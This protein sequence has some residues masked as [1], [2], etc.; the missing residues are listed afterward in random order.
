[1]PRLLSRANS[2]RH[3]TFLGAV[4]TALASLTVLHAAQN[5]GSE[6]SRMQAAAADAMQRKID[7]IKSNADAASV[8]QRPTVF[9]QS[10]INAYFA[11]HRVRTP[12]GVKAARFVLGRA[13]VTAYAR[14]DFDQI[15]EPARSRNPLLSIFSGT[16][17]VQVLCDASGSGG[18]THVNIRSVMLDGVSIPRMALQMFIEKWVNPKYPTIRLDGDYKLPA[19]IDTVTIEQR[20][21]IVTQK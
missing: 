6:T 9:T 21:G 2:R 13:Q 17:D 1:M 8:D 15:T 4:A 14:I 3:L 19:R 18:M 20:S 5:A 10:E 16:H 12:D 11:D 7:F